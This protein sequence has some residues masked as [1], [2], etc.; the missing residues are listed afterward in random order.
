[1]SGMGQQGM[2]SGQYPMFAGT[3][4][5]NKSVP[6][7]VGVGGVGASSAATGSPAYFPQQ[8]N[9]QFGGITPG[10]DMSGMPAQGMRL[11]GSTGM[12]AQGMGFAPN[13]PFPG[14]G[15]PIAAGMPAQGMRLP[16]TTGMPAQGMGYAQGMAPTLPPGAV[17]DPRR[18]MNPPRRGLL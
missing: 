15:Q 16:G 3:N 10:A 12:P 2:G 6:G 9:P 11:P 17:I 1:M 8:P 4:I 14:G 7:Q 5:P 18:K 13:L